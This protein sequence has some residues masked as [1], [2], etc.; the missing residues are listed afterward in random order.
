[1]PQVQRPAPGCCWARRSIRP[2]SKR[3]SP[4]GSQPAPG[5]ISMPPPARVRAETVRR[6][7]AIVLGRS[8]ISPD[9]AQVAAA[10]L[11]G[12][13]AHG[14]ALLPW[15]P[16]SAA[17]R[18]RAG[19][20]RAVDPTLPDLGDEAL[21]ADLEAGWH[22]C[23]RAAT[24]SMPSMTRCWP[25]RCATGSAGT[26]RRAA[27]GTRPGAVHD[28]RRQQPRH[29]L[30]RGWRPRRRCAGAGAVRPHP[31]SDGRQC[32]VDAAADVAGRAAHPGD[33]GPA[34]LLGRQLGRSAAR[35]ARALPEAPLARRPGSGAADAARPQA[36]TGLR[37]AKSGRAARLG[38]GV[39]PVAVADCDTW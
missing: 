12:V 35:A 10:L 5:L 26:G 33:A 22:R 18:A 21:L 8:A 1:M 38:H 2:A 24:G 36:R 17:L 3:C 23:S 20:A 9:P 7:G 32:A 28:A 16:A 37:A 30:C 25:M 11:A 27:G 14:L 6:L 13:R 39:L 29:R 15:G 34:A 31:A 4:T 19:F